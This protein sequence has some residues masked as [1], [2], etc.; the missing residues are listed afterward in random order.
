MPASR[1]AGAQF[2]EFL[3]DPGGEL[4]RRST[5]SAIC[6]RPGWAMTTTSRTAHRICA[7]LE[8][9]SARGVACYVM[10]GN[11]DF[12]LQGGFERRTGARLIADPIDHR[13]VWRAGAA[14]A[15]RC[16]VHRRPALSAAARAWCAIRAGSGVSCAC[17]CACGAASPSRRGTAAAGTRSARRAQIMDADEAGGARR[18]ARLRRAHPDPRA[19]PSAGRARVRARRREPARRIVLG[20]WHDQGSACPGTPDGFRLEELPRVRAVASDRAPEWT[21]QQR[22]RR[23]SGVKS[24]AVARAAPPGA[25]RQAAVAGHAP[26]RAAARVRSR[27]YSSKCRASERARPP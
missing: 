11:R 18:D 10:H 2:V 3:R 16:A 8:R 20:A 19:Y 13:S 25:A 22:I 5:S 9:L 12:L 26:D 17:R 14:D 23:P 15:R 1:Q 24:A 6:S 7:A 27:R 21:A 4:P